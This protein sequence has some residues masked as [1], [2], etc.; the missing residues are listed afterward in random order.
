MLIKFIEAGP[1]E[2]LW[3]GL[4]IVF[5]MI[6]VSMLQSFFLAYYFNRM[7]VI[8]LRIRSALTASIYRKSLVLGNT[9]RKDTTIGE[10]VNLMSV[11]SQRFTDLMAWLNLLWSA[12]LQI[13]LAIYFLYLELGLSV[14]AGVAVM[15]LMIPLN[16][17]V[18][19][20]SKKMQTRQMKQKDERVKAMN[21]ILNGIKVIKLYAWEESFMAQILG[22]RKKEVKELKNMAYLGAVGIFLWMC[23]PFLVALTSFAIYV[24]SDESHILDAQKA[25]VSLALFNLLRFPLTMLPNMITSL[26]MTAVSVKRLN[27]Y[28]NS[29]ELEKYVTYNAELDAITI[30]NGSFSWSTLSEENKDDTS[31]A[32]V[33]LNNINL[34]VPKGSFLAIVGNVGAGKSSLLSAILGE[35]QKLDGR[36]NISGNPSI[37]YVPQQA[38][39]QNVTLKENILFGAP[40]ED[41]KYNRVIHACALK[42]DLDILPGG[43][44]TEIGE[45][46]INLSGGQKQRVNLARAC[47]S[48]ADLYLMDDP[49][50]AVDSHVAKHLFDKVLSSKTGL[51]KDKTRILA[52]NNIALLPQLDNIIVLKNG[53]V[54]EIGTYK[55]LMGKNQDFAEFVRNFSL[56][57]E[58]EPASPTTPT[59]ERQISLQKE[60]RSG[61]MDQHV[62]TT[63][64]KNKLIEAEKTETGKVKL[65]VY[66]QYFKTIALPWALMI[67][68]G[69]F[70]MQAASG[71]S[72]YWLSL[73]ST[74]VPIN[75]NGTLVS[76]K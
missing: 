42:P 32:N 38:W 18:A 50:S 48:G 16:A 10:I 53:K 61:S 73:W 36:V 37:A 21:E 67:F 71:G 39:I 33:I 59:F 65:A 76:M 13:V 23:A 5:L 43:D 15:V 29:P 41:R 60:E 26:I 56:H 11:D 7:M 55:E 19:T 46:G 62:K 17:V 72:N 30:E 57:K 44:E 58:E 54:S 40:L 22:L 4:L 75:T 20:Y 31:N 35:M 69:F 14:F 3:H 24:L 8:G 64:Q 27:K 6:A 47:Y 45:K 51:L 74:D 49:L 1:E 66:I 34:S 63:E 52:T 68:F 70:G 25:F 12:P 28:L 2:P 9:A